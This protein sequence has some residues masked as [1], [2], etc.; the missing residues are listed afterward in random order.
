MARLFSRYFNTDINDLIEGIGEVELDEINQPVSDD[1]EK[2]KETQK[3]LME[4]LKIVDHFSILSPAQKEWLASQIMGNLTLRDITTESLEDSYNN[5][6]YIPS[7]GGFYTR[8]NSTMYREIDEIYTRH[9]RGYNQKNLTA[10]SGELK[11]MEDAQ[12]EL[13]E[14]EFDFF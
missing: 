1:E 8:Q 3:L 11:S 13:E 5:T 7:P 2:D 9:K 6:G 12:I 4:Q 14:D 10:L